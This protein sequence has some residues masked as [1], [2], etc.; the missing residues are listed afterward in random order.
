LTPDPA[1]AFDKARI[2]LVA[3]KS[4]ATQEMA[5]LIARYAPADSI[6]VSLQNGVG[7]AD[8]LQKNLPESMT[9]IA[10]MVPFNVV[11]SDAG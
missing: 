11:Q 8:V 10:G 7:N 2:I 1:T 6:V 4:G 5:G 3:V 9:V